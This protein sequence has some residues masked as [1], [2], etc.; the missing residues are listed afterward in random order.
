MKAFCPTLFSSVSDLSISLIV[1]EV[2]CVEE[3][4]PKAGVTALSSSH[5][6]DNMQWPL[7]CVSIA[8]LFCSSGSGTG[9]CIDLRGYWWI[10]TPVSIHHPAT[11]VKSSLSDCITGKNCGHSWGSV[12][13]TTGKCVWHLVIS[14]HQWFNLHLSQN[15][16][17]SLTLGLS[18]VHLSLS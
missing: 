7:G 12:E 11:W 3:V 18:R 1:E 16:G 17:H 13:D 5:V 6:I 2:V 14:T 4:V 8:E 9:L 10:L 15:M